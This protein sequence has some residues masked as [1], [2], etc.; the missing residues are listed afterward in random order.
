MLNPKQMNF[1]I[2]IDG[3]IAAAPAIYCDLMC[4]LKADGNRVY[5]LSGNGNNGPSGNT[6]QEKCDYL[7]KVGVTQC[8]DSLTVV[9]GDIPA[10][11]ALWCQE[12]KVDVAIDNDKN[13]SKAL[14]AA[15]VPLVLVP[16]A[17]RSPQK[18]GKK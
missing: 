1:M 10:Q 4:A 12:H 8:W 9:T 17:T 2:D 6:W 18:K 5:I 15:G 3:T 14:I 16:W 11:K 13:N 7:N